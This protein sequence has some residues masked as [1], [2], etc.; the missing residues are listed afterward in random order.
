MN[1]RTSPL[2]VVLAVVAFA[3]ESGTQTVR[4][5]VAPPSPA[6]GFAT[7]VKSFLSDNCYPCH[8]DKTTS[9]KRGGVSIIGDRA[10]F[11]L[12]HEFL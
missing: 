5:P 12:S 3:A 4:K 6:P 8:N 11:G 2:F 10:A 7:S 9:G 1:F